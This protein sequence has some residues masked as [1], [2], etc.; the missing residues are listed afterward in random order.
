MVLS[1]IE[2]VIEIQNV[3]LEKLPCL[4]S[5]SCACL[6]IFGAV[7]FSV[8]WL[9]AP[10]QLVQYQERL[11]L[12]LI[13]YRSIRAYLGCTCSSYVAMVPAYSVRQASLTSNFGQYQEFLISISLTLS[14]TLISICFSNVGAH[15]P[16]DFFTTMP[17]SRSCFDSLFS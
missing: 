13:G 12:S 15:C 3:E 11:V 2:P 5:L 4:G 10:L 16:S 14:L 7:I 8:L 6:R 17:Y 9:V 1:Q